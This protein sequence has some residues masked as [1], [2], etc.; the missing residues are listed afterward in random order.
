MNRWVLVN[1]KMCLPFLQFCMVMVE[2]YNKQT[3]IPD[4]NIRSISF[5]IYL[6]HRQ[7]MALFDS[8]KPFIIESDALF[9]KNPLSA[10]REGLRMLFPHPSPHSW[11]YDLEQF[12]GLCARSGRHFFR[13]T[14][15]V[16]SFTFWGPPFRTH[17]LNILLIMYFLFVYYIFLLFLW[18][19]GYELYREMFFI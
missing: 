10:G 15:K 17:F 7:V 19:G 9:L 2:N 14:Q 11:E 16:R 18:E 6:L 8:Q 5:S 4:H 13:N 1:L 12:R 3:K